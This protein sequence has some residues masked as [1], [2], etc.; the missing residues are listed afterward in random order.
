MATNIDKDSISQ[1]I[2]QK[3][4]VNKKSPNGY[5]SLHLCNFDRREIEHTPGT[6][7]DKKEDDS[8]Q[9]PTPNTPIETPQ[10]PIQSVTPLFQNVKQI[11][12]P[13]VQQKT[14]TF[15]QFE[16]LLTSHLE[17]RLTAIQEKLE[18]YLKKPV[19]QLQI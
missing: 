5:D 6:K 8:V 13:S 17:K 12:K 19:E 14:P 4:L 1:L 11:P 7:S 9:T 15:E 2:N 18:S 3:V 16:T 10:F